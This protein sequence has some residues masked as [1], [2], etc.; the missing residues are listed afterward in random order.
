MNEAQKVEKKGTEGGR[1]Q[2]ERKLKKGKE[3]KKSKRIK[4]R[5]RSTMAITK[6]VGRR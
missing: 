2:E 5:V 6:E 4:D 3:G 1:Q